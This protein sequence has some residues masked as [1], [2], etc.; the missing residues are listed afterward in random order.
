MNIEEQIKNPITI[1]IT[2]EENSIYV[3]GIRTPLL[4]NVIFEDEHYG[5]NLVTEENGV[6]LESIYPTQCS[7]LSVR[8]E[9]NSIEI[10]ECNKNSCWKFTKSGKLLQSSHNDFNDTYSKESSKEVIH[11][12]EPILK[13]PLVIKLSN[14]PKKCLIL[15]EYSKENMYIYP[16]KIMLN[17]HYGFILLIDNKEVF[18]PTQN[19]IEQVIINDL[20]KKYLRIVEEGKQSHWLFELDGELLQSGYI[21]EDRKYRI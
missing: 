14:D 2:K 8:V 11:Y 1:K 21:K 13:S 17:N 3:D 7:L 20:E 18:Y 9:N 6:L 19:R 12:E 16:G 15:D 4:P 5:F 10:L